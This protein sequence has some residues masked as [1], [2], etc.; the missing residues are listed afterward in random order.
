M[1]I[2]ITHKGKEFTISGKNPTDVAQKAI[3]KV[4]EIE[5]AANHE[6]IKD[7]RAFFKEYAK[8][9]VRT[10]LAGKKS[11]SY[12]KEVKG[13]LKNYL[14]PYFGDIALAKIT[15]E[16]IQHF[17]DEMR[18]VKNPG[19]DLG[20]KT[21][22]SVLFFMA[23]ILSSAIEDGYLQ[24]NPAKSSRLCITGKPEREVPSWSESDWCKLYTEVLPK[25]TYQQ[26]RLFL[27]I[28]MFHG[29]RKG[30][31]AALTWDD[32]DLEH[33]TLTVRRAVQ[34]VKGDQGCNQGLLK[35]PKTKNGY[36][37][38]ALSEFVIPYLKE[39]DKTTPYLIHGIRY[40]S[41]VGTNPPSLN[42]VENLIKR[43]RAACEACGIE[44]KYQSHELRHTV[45]TFDCNAGIDDKTLANNH[46]HYNAQ[47]SK[48]KYARS[49]ETQR[50]R[51][52]KTSDSFMKDVLFTNNR[53]G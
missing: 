6:F 29:L 17:L 34:W 49:L 21:K 4:L 37:T 18:S 30:E 47:F 5:A 33:G 44:Q 38:I 14:N 20:V 48:E 25:L 42:A 52:R 36:R 27:L 23:A 51:A 24:R 22:R 31:I 28:D 9:Y 1:R 7:T 40:P 50:T 45:I 12:L 2:T 32:I 41:R 19:E 3:D 13:Y 39:A 53:V 16:S 35:G 11:G 8:Y 46:G 10:Y 43:I 15:T 26:D